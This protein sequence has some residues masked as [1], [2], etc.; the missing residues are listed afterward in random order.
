VHSGDGGWKPQTKQ[1]ALFRA[2]HTHSRRESLRQAV[3]LCYMPRRR[4]F[5]VVT[6]HPQFDII[7]NSPYVLSAHFSV[8]HACEKFPNSPPM[9]ITF[10]DCEKKTD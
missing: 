7:A 6:I 9:P 2:T 8:Y 10:L 3:L 5:F 4:G 1:T